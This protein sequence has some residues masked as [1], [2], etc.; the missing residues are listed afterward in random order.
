MRQTSKSTSR[1][2]K[3]SDDRKDCESNLPSS[4]TSQKIGLLR[5]NTSSCT[6]VDIRISWIVQVDITDRYRVL[7]RLLEMDPQV[8]IKVRIVHCFIEVDA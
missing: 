5:S 4:F 2:R 3:H 1:K 8:I 6:Q 7:H